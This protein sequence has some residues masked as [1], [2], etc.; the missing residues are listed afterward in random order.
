MKLRFSFLIATLLC[1]HSFTDTLQARVLPAQAV[2]IVPVANAFN[3]YRSKKFPTATYEQIKNLYHNA[4][5]SN[6][7]GGFT[8]LHQFLLHEV[9]TV[10]EEK[11][12]ELIVRAPDHFFQNNPNCD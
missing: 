8:R 10:I 7:I 9:V 1:F 12:G 11:D 6:T 5:A 3:K 2:C 4:F